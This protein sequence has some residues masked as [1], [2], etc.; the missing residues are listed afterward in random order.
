MASGFEAINHPTESIPKNVHFRKALPQGQRKG[1]NLCGQSERKMKS[2]KLECVILCC[3]ADRYYC[4]S[5]RSHSNDFQFRLPIDHFCLFWNWK[6]FQ[7]QYFV[8]QLELRASPNRML[9]W[10]F[11]IFN[12]LNKSWSVSIISFCLVQW[13]TNFVSKGF[14]HLPFTQA[15]ELTFDPYVIVDDQTSIIHAINSDI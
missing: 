12:M 1:I 5:K 11:C 3:S 8:S 7:F 9:L 2:N 15:W 13:T 10:K 6:N 14:N 4:V